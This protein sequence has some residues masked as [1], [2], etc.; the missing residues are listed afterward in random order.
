MFEVNF[1]NLRPAFIRADPESEK[2]TDDLTVIF[3]LSGSVG[4]K[5]AC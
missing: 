4:V 2:K 1:T 3:V 5:A